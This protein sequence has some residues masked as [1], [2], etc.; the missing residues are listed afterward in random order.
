MHSIWQLDLSF[1]DMGYQLG[2]HAVVAIQKDRRVLRSIE[3][4][5]HECKIRCVLRSTWERQ[6]KYLSSAPA[7]CSRADL[8]KSVALQNAEHSEFATGL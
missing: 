7:G 4:V 8:G 3:A 6:E 5:S 2:M 1:A